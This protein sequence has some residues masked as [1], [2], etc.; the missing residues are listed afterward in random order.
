MSSGV[1]RTR[2]TYVVNALAE[3]LV[4]A[5]LSKHYLPER[6]VTLPE[7]PTTPSGKIQKFKLREM[8]G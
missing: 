1:S 6:V 3:Y 2:R 7:L 5:G 8:I 4:A